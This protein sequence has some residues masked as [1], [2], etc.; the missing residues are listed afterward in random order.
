VIKRYVCFDDG[1]TRCFNR[2]ELEYPEP[3]RARRIRDKQR[4]KAKARRVFGQRLGPENFRGRQEYAE[5]Q[6]ANE[7]LADHP[8]HCQKP[9]CNR[10]RDY[11]GPTMQERRFMAAQRPDGNI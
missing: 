5:W 3:T 11:E 2:H 6:K 8:A 10:A 4:M 1:V 7:Q 9:C